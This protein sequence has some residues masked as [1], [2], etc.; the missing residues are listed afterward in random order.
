MNTIK[1]FRI[2]CIS[3]NKRMKGKKTTTKRTTEK[4]KKIT[5]LVLSVMGEVRFFF[6]LQDWY[7][8][9]FWALKFNDFMANF[10]SIFPCSVRSAQY[11]RVKLLASYTKSHF[12]C[13]CKC[14][15]IRAGMVGARSSA[16]YRLSQCAFFFLKI[17]WLWNDILRKTEEKSARAHN[18]PKHHTETRYE[19][20]VSI[21]Q[22]WTRTMY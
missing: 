1:T 10:C 19:L 3:C 22:L 17:L 2:L 16:F 18:I 4:T 20:H 5:L 12:M 15:S 14:K 8:H 13:K 11:F 21:S 6:S 9:A 7:V